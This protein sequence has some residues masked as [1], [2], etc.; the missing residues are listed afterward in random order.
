[1]I[2][3]ALVISSS[4]VSAQVMQPKVKLPPPVPTSPQQ[5][6]DAQTDAEKKANEDNTPPAGGDPAGV[7]PADT[8]P[9][10]V[11]PG[12]ET[13]APMRPVVSQSNAPEQQK[14][15][16]AMP[17]ADGISS[18]NTLPIHFTLTPG[19]YVVVKGRAFGNANGALEA[20]LPGYPN[21]PTPLTVSAW[22]DNTIQ[23]QLPVGITGVLDGPLTLRLTTASQQVFESKPGNF[24]ARRQAYWVTANIPQYIAAPNEYPIRQQSE[25]EL[26]E[27]DVRGFTNDGTLYRYTV[28]ALQ[29]INSC[30]GEDRL[31]AKQLPG[32]FV[33]DSI[34]I[35]TPPL[36]GFNAS[37]PTP[38]GGDAPNAV[39]HRGSYAL[40]S[41]GSGVF[42]VQRAC[43]RNAP[44]PG[45]TTFFPSP[46][47]KNYLLHFVSV[48][49]V[50]VKLWGPQGTN[51]PF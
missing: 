8:P 1:M 50:R 38:P 37:G 21:N 46:W 41:V 23:A 45:Y 39:W 34:E 3:A 51:P 35:E 33:V 14:M 2:L 19:D 10:S 43:Q 22:D 47:M 32:G 5:T 12:L 4:A 40:K 48:Y 26:A 15:Q 18:V 17:L 6:Q 25:H 13:A 36:S 11:P 44:W 28:E 20:I 9:E 49:R 16:S 24:K 31:I 30:A 7:P 27:G 42:D 29:P